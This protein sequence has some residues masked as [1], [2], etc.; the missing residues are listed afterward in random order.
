MNNLEKIT[1]NTEETVTIEELKTVLEKTKPK[2][3]IGF[4][5]S[6]S[7][8]LGWKICS[9]KIKDFIDCGFDFI[10][11]LADWHAYINDKLG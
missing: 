10:I 7:V 4:E 3:Y 8:H 1:S 6:G 2:A 9:N 5:P 11:L